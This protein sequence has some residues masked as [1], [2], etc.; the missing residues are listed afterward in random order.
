MQTAFE[1]TLNVEVLIVI[2]LAGLVF[3]GVVG[4]RMATRFRAR[5]ARM[6]QPWLVAFALVWFLF[7]AATI[8]FRI[9]FDWLGAKD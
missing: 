4:P 5:W 7:C 6:S 1:K 3:A 9:V 8:A 2:A